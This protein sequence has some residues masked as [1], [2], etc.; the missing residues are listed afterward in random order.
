MVSAADAAACGYDDAEVD[1]LCRRQEWTRL[2]RGLY[3]PFP[4][5]P[6]TERLRLDCAAALRALDVKDA[7]LAHVSAARLWG[8]KWR[9]DPVSSDVWIACDV[10]GKPR[11]YPGLRL[12]PSK[13][14]AE[15]VTTLD[16]LPVT[17]PARTAVD[18]ARHLEFEPAVVVV[19]SLR[20]LYGIGDAALSAVLERSAGW[21]HIKRA[22]RV[23]AFS[24]ALSESPLES[25]ARLAFRRADVP[26][27]RQQAE[28]LDANGDRR[29]LDFLFG[30][31][32][33]VETDGRIKY[34]TPEDLWEEKRRAD[35]LLEAGVHLLRLGAA[36]L[37]GDPRAL[38]RRIIE[39]MMRAGDWPE[40]VGPV[41]H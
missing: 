9:Q 17:T 33:G 11:Y 7:A 15:D 1:R 2:R 3:Y 39:H 32:S 24:S 19:E 18:L 23:I 20:H 27:Y 41:A 10:P 30:R 38:R 37:H 25:E 29:R 16:G 26:G 36:D 8:A 14:A 6:A 28:F 13:L 5:P 4:D 35:A 31:R 12:L 21:P 34:R 40:D 22:R